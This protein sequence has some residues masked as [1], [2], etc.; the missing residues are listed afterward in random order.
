MLGSNQNANRTYL[1]VGFGKIRQKSLDGKPIT[2]DTV[3]AKKHETQS[4][5]ESWSIDYDFLEGKIENIFYKEDK[6]FGSSFEV[7]IS[8]AADEY[9]LSFKE[10]SRFWVDFAC[11]LPNIDLGNK[12]KITAYDFEYKGK[13]HV[14]ISLLQNGV[15]ITNFYS[16]KTENGWITKHGF[17]N[18]ENTNWTDKDDIKIYMIAVKKFLRSEFNTRIESMFTG[19]VKSKTDEQH[20]EQYET[21]IPPF[22]TEEDLPF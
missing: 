11:K 15:K 22:P 20:P 5:A 10:D 7:V 3:G 14:G 18:S 6:D 17:P 1:S 16:E 13:R 19:T 21:D 12:V 2:G 8:D 4:G 9:Q